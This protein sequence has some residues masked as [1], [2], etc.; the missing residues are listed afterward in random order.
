MTFLDR[1][2][3][4]LWLQPFNSGRPTTM[5]VAMH[6]NESFYPF[7]TGPEVDYLVQTV[8]FRERPGVTRLELVFATRDSGAV[9]G[10]FQRDVTLYDR[11][12]DSLSCATGRLDPEVRARDRRNPSLDYAVDLVAFPVDNARD[13]VW[14][15]SQIADT[16]TRGFGGRMEGVPV[17]SFSGGGV[18][19][20][21][22]LL[23]DRIAFEPASGLL[24]RPGG[25]GV[26]SP[27]R[28]YLS[29]ENVPI[30]FEAYNLASG[31]DGLSRYRVHITI[32]K[33]TPAHPRMSRPALFDFKTPPRPSVESRFE[34]GAEPGDVNRMLDLAV[35]HLASGS[36]RLT[37]GVE[38]LV[39]GGRAT[40]SAR[41]KIVDPPKPRGKKK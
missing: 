41:F 19:L 34:E 5:D 16:L 37:L 14:V 6:H 2:L 26:P 7:A 22:L 24:G 21:D 31:E 3:S 20:S 36:Y 28:V 12:W 11:S 1:N 13:T 33:A 17:R 38:D 25:W 9:P 10:R 18:L 15:G 27:D 8:Q 39:A 29:G 4:G 30:Y 40:S 23:M 35:G 32:E